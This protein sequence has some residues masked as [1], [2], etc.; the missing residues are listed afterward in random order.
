MSDY[1]LFCHVN[2]PLVRQE[3][4]MVLQSKCRPMREGAKPG[5]H[6]IQMWFYQHRIFDDET[7]L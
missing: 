1:I 2:V 6:V 3:V 7:N 5:G 4:R